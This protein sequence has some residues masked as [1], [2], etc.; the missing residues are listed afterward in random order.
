M[1]CA[2][3]NTKAKKMHEIQKKTLHVEFV[4]KKD[5][6]YRGKHLYYSEI[7]EP[8]QNGLMYMCIGA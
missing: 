3:L 6:L 7:I 1:H 2:I 5:D 8:V 4:M